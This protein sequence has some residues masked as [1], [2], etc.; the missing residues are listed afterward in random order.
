MHL[1]RYS[2][3]RIYKITTYL[4]MITENDHL[5]EFGSCRIHIWQSDDRKQE[6]RLYGKMYDSMMKIRDEASA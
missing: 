5:W 1:E 3:Y 2:I 4:L 6:Y